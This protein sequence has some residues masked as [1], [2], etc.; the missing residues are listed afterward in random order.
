ML[1]PCVQVQTHHGEWAP[2]LL[3]EEGCKENCETGE[4]CWRALSSPG[5]RWQP[6]LILWP[7]QQAQTTSAFRSRVLLWRHLVTD[8][9]EMA[10]VFYN[11]FC[12]VFTIEDAD[13]IPEPV[14]VHAAENT[15]TDIAS[16]DPEFEAKLK[17][18]K[19]AGSNGFLSNVLKA[20]ADCVIPHLFQFF[21]RSLT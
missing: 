7:C 3:T 6:Q 13:N 10:R 11:Y 9:K 15:L 18:D 21:N 19:A 12:N 20:V 5:E 2:T 16:A 1:L 17:P 14:I 8:D 4:G